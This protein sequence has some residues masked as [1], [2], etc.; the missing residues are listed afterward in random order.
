LACKTQVKFKSHFSGKKSA[1]Y[2]PGNTVTPHM[3]KVQVG[4]ACLLYHCWFY[5][6]FTDVRWV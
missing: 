5:I 4:Y 1:S 6:H 3:N 2:G